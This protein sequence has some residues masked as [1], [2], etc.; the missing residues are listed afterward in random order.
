MRFA[1]LRQL[2][3]ASRPGPRAVERAGDAVM[4]RVGKPS[5]LVQQHF[6][7]AAIDPREGVARGESVRFVVQGG[8]FEER[9][10]GEPDASSQVAIPSR[11]DENHNTWA[12]A[13]CDFEGRLEVERDAAGR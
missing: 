9:W 2:G 1:R 7:R 6:I 3:T 5:T 11:P 13:A 10:A 12:R 8:A 4:V